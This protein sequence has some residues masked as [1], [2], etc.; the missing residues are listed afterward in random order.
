MKSSE[1]VAS[2]KEDFGDNVQLPV[3]FSFSDTPLSEP[4]EGL[5]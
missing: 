1:F 5:R 4:K 3:A 2:L